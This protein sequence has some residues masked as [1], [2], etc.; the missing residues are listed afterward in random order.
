[1]ADFQSAFKLGLQAS[2][3]AGLA[4]NQIE[5]VFDEFARQVSEASRGAIAVERQTVRQAIKAKKSIYDLAAGILPDYKLVNVLKAL[6]VGSKASQELCEY[7]LSPAGYPVELRY[8]DV[9]EDCHSKKSLE[10]GLVSLLAAPQTGDK[11]R[12]L[13]QARPPAPGDPEPTP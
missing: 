3:Q 6:A 5:T 12:A 7:E 13:L 4:R 9:T 11:L 10:D 8:A 1:M 2:E